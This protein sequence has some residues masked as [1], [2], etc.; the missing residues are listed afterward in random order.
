MSRLFTLLFIFTVFHGYSQEPLEN[1][2]FKF[3]ITNVPDSIDSVAFMANYY[4]S[5]QYYRDTAYFEKGGVLNFTGSSVNG[6]IY[7]VIFQDRKTYFE[8]VVNENSIEM[9]TDFNDLIPKMKVKKSVEN[10]HFYE[11]LRFINSKSTMAAPIQEQMNALGEEDEEMK[12]KFRDKLNEIEKDV[13]AFKREFI[14]KYPD[15]LATK[16]FRATAD[17]EVGDFK[18]IE[19]EE[20]R[21]KTRF[22]EFRDHYLDDVDFTDDRLLR[23]PVLHNKMMHYITKLTPQIPD[24]INKAADHLVELA[25]P[26]PEVFK[27]VVHTI[28]NKYEGAQIM[29]MD[30]VLVHMGQKYYCSGQVDWMSEKKLEEFCE[31][32]EAMAPL[33]IGKK[34]PNLILL[35]TNGVWQNMHEIDAPY[36]ALYFWDSGCGHCKKVTP[37]LKEFYE[38]YKEKGVVVYAVGTEF[39][40]EEWK[41]Y[42][43]KKDLPFINVSDTPD[44]NENAQELIMEGKTTLE[45][46]N[47]RTTYDIFSTPRLFL[48]DEDKTIIATKLTPEQLGDFI[49]NDMERKQKESEKAAN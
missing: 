41:Q 38:T 36:T 25:R 5:K 14:G 47:F 30:A 17:P 1:Y 15:L 46:L 8:F 18:E 39:E 34:A 22:K 31:R 44:A 21:R 27:Y 3:R 10:T 7:S 33:L 49:D 42:I 2:D 48:L 23:T 4:G 26:N 24:S 37:K 40:V 13:I 29:G 9:E 43:K 16:V 28:T 19:D 45:S 6:G 12:Q 20:E 11:Y 32:V 35:D